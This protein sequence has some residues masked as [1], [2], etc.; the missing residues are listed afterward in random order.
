MNM[1]RF[2]KI[3]LTGLGCALGIA[4]I[5]CTARLAVAEPPSD[6]TYKGMKTCLMCHNGTHKEL[7]AAFAKTAHPQALRTPDEQ[8]AIA[9]VFAADSP[10][11]KEDIAFVLGVGHRH[12]AYIGKDM[13]T[14]PGQW[15]AKE[16]KWIP[17][18]VL[19]AQQ[20]CMPCH[21]TGLDSAT[22]AYVDKGVAC[23]ACH[24][25]GSAHAATGDK[26]KIGQ[27]SKLTPASQAMICGRCHSV[28]VSKEGGLKYPAGLK[29]GADLASVFTLSEVTGPKQNQQYNE[30]LTS[31][32]AKGT[33]V[34]GCVMCH[35]V[36]GKASAN[37]FQLKKPEVELCSGCHAGAIAKAEH[38]KIAAGMK[39]DMC[40]MP[41]GMH[42][43]A[44]PAK[45]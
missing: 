37:E 21:V 14:L 35:D 3:G 29:Y 17:Q 5:L 1:K 16:K 43:F 19:D 31:K 36:H 44:V 27:V 26:T 11:K 39:C 38:P 4:V 41:Q 8:N 10:V 23:E 13:K 7:T 25:P 15:D 12:Q 28:G 18:P 22:K 9:A 45:G 40:H 2:E 24:G 34:V 32:H 33:V 30:W 6:A 20:E 42:T